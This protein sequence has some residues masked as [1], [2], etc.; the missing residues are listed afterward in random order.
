[1]FQ[2]ININ[3]DFYLTVFKIPKSATFKE[4]LKKQDV[5]IFALLESQTQFT[6]VVSS[7]AL[8]LT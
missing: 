7:P 5:L 2:N 4:N 8:T 1:M 3:F 6:G